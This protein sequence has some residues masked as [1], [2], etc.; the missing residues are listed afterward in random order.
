MSKTHARINAALAYSG[1]V[2]ERIRFAVRE[3]SGR[4]VTRIYTPRDTEIRI[5]VRHNL[6]RR[7][8]ESH[9]NFPLRKIFREGCYQPL[10][11]IDSAIKRSGRR[12]CVL[13]LGGHLGYFAAFV[14]A[15]YPQANVVTFEPKPEHAH[16]I[17]ACIE[18]NGLQERWQLVEA[19][20]H[21]D[22]GTLRLAAGRSIGSRLASLSGEQENVMEVAARNVFSYVD[23]A[24]LVKIDIE[25]AEWPLI[26]DERFAAACPRAVVIEYHSLGCPGPNPKRVATE[27]FTELGYEVHAPA[28]DT[29]PDSA[30]FWGAVFSGLG[31]PESWSRRAR[32]YRQRPVRPLQASSSRTGS[33]RRSER[34][35]REASARAP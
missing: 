24:D 10:P 4:R 15:R 5:C 12:A 26:L 23:R 11:I 33:K 28:W 14:L 2:R 1:L 32:G 3:L 20:A 7:G 27:R 29:N 16:W 30:P 35:P 6:R 19:C 22:D 17:R 21:T 31:A 9:D 18:I 34:L 25:G 8:W 13:D